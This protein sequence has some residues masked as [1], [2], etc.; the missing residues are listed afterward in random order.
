MLL[1]LATAAA[2]AW[3]I[4]DALAWAGLA[5]LTLVWA[6]TGLWQVPAHRRLEDGYD[7]R[8][9]RRLVY[10][11]WVRTITWS[12]RGVLAYALLVAHR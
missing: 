10:T 3:V 4:G 8:I 12:A 1:E 9:H 7:A 5:L 11:N 2:V 6:S